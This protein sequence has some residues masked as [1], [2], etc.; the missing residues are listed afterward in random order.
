MKPAL[1]DLFCG[2]GGATIGAAA[3]GFDVLGIEYDRDAG[4]VHEAH[5]G[6]CIHADIRDHAAWLPRALAWLEGRPLRVWASPPCQAFSSAGKRLGAK[7]ERNGWPW[8][9]GAIDALRSAGVVIEWIACENVTGMLHHLSAANCAHGAR[10]NPIECSGCYWHNVILRDAA[11]RFRSV[12][13]KALDA[14]DFGTPQHRRRVILSCGPVAA[15]WPARSHH[16]IGGAALPWWLTV[17]DAL[18]HP[19]TGGVREGAALLNGGRDDVS[20]EPSPTVST[21]GST[22]ALYVRQ[23]GMRPPIVVPA[24]RPSPCVQGGS[25]NDTPIRIVDDMRAVRA[26]DSHD[27]DAPAKSVR[28]S[29]GP[30]NI[31]AESGVARHLGRR[32]TP[33]ENAML[34]AWPDV[35]PA[36]AAARTVSARYRIVGNAVPPPFACALISSLLPLGLPRSTAQLAL[37]ERAA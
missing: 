16:P 10:P 8:L 36:L 4:A 34:Q 24:D 26:W 20:D 25:H 7:D 17:M 11:A 28:G 23:T 15:A 19:V 18:G 13:W 31:G 14:V 12:Q 9:W 35:I 37:W 22:G 29:N 32:A 33:A 2:G 1:L 30:Q 5:A 27:L 6:P 3:A 21:F